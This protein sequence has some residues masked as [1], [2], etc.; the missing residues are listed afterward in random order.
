MTQLL[1]VKSMSRNLPPN[2]T[3]A[4]DRCL[5]KGCSLSPAPPAIIIVKTLSIVF[6]PTH[7]RIADAAFSSTTIVQGTNI[8]TFAYTNAFVRVSTLLVTIPAAWF[9]SRAFSKSFASFSSPITSL[10]QLLKSFL[11]EF[12]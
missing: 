6:S 1:S 12:E 10:I 3:A 11:S 8:D 2:G 4:L 7:S 5:V 9:R